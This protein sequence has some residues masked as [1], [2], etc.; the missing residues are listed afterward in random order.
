MFTARSICDDQA[1][2]DVWIGLLLL[3]HVRM[4]LVNTTT[5]E[6]IKGRRW[7]DNSMH[8]K[9]FYVRY[10]TNFYRFFF[11]PGSES[12]R[13]TVAYGR[14]PNQVRLLYGCPRHEDMCEVGVAS[15]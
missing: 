7:V 2:H 13:I 15:F 12:G 1:Y 11:H 6:S 9:P 4:V 3:T 8:G 10:P 5:Y 14:V